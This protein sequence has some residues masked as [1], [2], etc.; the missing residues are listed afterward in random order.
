MSDVLT[1]E[2]VTEIA[3]RAQLA[4][5]VSERDKWRAERNRLAAAL[6]E[7]TTERDALLKATLANKPLEPEV[8][9]A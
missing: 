9:H 4:E 1:P 7:T 3:L 2:E 6:A 8:P 5:V